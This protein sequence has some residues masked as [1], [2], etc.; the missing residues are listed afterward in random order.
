LREEPMRLSALSKKLEITTAE[1]SRHLDRLSKAK[2]IDRDSDSN[3]SITPFSAI[4]IGEIAKLEFL[5]KNIDFFLAHDLSHLPE[6]LHWLDS[7]AK[8]SFTSGTLET[9]SIIKE[10]SINAEEYIHV[11]S[12]EVMRGLVELDSKKN[13]EGVVIKKIYPEDADIPKEY[14][15]R[16]GESFEIRTLKMVPLGLKMTEK[17]AGVAIR[18]A[19]G[20]VDYSMGLIG[21]D[22]SF[23]RWVDAIFGHF[24]KE[25]EPWP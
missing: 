2:L 16:T 15:S 17:M 1:V 20:K 21:E 6:H 14:R 11:I 12:V 7:M 24:W 23:R 25:A 18:D 22:E 3:Y 9:S 8:G 13:D 5:T 19:R 10:A 4:I